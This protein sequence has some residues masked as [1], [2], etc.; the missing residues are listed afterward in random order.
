M[1]NT[2]TVPSK[3]LTRVI[4]SKNKKRTHRLGGLTGAKLTTPWT[5][6]RLI[7]RSLS[8]LR[9]FVAPNGTVAT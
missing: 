1:M 4:N 6:P 7:S 3:L 5:L 8:S 9:P 2:L